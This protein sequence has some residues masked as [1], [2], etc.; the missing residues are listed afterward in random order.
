MHKNTDTT[1]SIKIIETQVESDGSRLSQPIL[2]ID[3]Q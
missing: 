2:C 1:D 3:E